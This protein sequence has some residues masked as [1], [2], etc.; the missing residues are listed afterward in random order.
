MNCKL[1]EG[2]FGKVYLV[3]SK[4]TG[5]EYALKAINCKKLNRDQKTLV[6]NEAKILEVLNHPNITKFVRVY[7][8][9]KENWNMVMEYVDG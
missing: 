2:A 5:T 9:R 3:N 7:K 4:V 8:D 1:G 6:R